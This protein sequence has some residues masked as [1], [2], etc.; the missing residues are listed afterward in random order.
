M[1]LPDKH[2]WL[3]EAVWSESANTGEDL[4]D[5]KDRVVEVAAGRSSFCNE[6][7]CVDYE[8]GFSDNPVRIEGIVALTLRAPVEPVDG[9]VM[10]LEEDETGYIY[11]VLDDGSTTGVHFDIT[12]GVTTNGIQLPQA[13]LEVI[14]RGYDTPTG[15]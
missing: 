13:L 9:G 12:T 10:F 11:F 1:R 8:L 7:G 6:N 14:L 2:R 5:I 15:F 3:Y 4:L